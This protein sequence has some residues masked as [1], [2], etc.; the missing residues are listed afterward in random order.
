MKGWDTTTAGFCTAGFCT[1]LHTGELTCQLIREDRFSTMILCSVRTGGP[2]LGKHLGLTHL[3]G[4]IF[5][6]LPFPQGIKHNWDIPGTPTARLT[7]STKSWRE[8][9]SPHSWATTSSTAR[10]GMLNG[11]PWV[12][13]NIIKNGPH[14]HNK[15]TPTHLPKTF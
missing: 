6:K 4:C 14:T 12:Q 5:W 11:H 7:I 1:C 15:Q 3:N 8:P 10:A 13:G 2:Y 9:S